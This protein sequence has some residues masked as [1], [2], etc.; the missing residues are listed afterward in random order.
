MKPVSHEWFLASSS[1]D[2]YYFD[3]DIMPV[4]DAVAGGHRLCARDEWGDAAVDEL[5]FALDHIDE[6]PGVYRN[7]SWWDRPLASGF[8]A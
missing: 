6:Q 4:D 7:R 8:A 2:P 1:N 3:R 5:A